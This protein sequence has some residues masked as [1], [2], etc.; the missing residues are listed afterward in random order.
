MR[1]EVVINRNKEGEGMES[2]DEEMEDVVH[3]KTV[4]SVVKHYY[5]YFVL[6]SVV[7]KLASILKRKVRMNKKWGFIRMKGYKKGKETPITQLVHS[8]L[9]RLV[10][11]LQGNIAL[12][13][14]RVI[15]KIK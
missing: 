7:N 12:T 2:E 14:V 3:H 15:H 5:S 9:K 8:K 11:I 6:A 13:K 10:G 4:L 1:G